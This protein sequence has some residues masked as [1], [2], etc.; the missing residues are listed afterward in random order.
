MKIAVIHLDN[1]N[2]CVYGKEPTQ[3]KK[4]YIQGN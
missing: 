3:N 4:K 1:V 2:Q